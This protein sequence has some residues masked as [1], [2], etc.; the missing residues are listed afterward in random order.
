MSIPV[1]GKKQAD[2]T[3]TVSLGDMVDYFE[4]TLAKKWARH[5]DDKIILEALIGHRDFLERAK[6]SELSESQVD[7]ITD[8]LTDLEVL[9]TEYTKKVDSE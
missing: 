6:A 4:G 5:N 3:E 8:A 2:G 9:I 1:K 7:G